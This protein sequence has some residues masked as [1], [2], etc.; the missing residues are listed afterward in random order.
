M[1]VAALVLS[2]TEAPPESLQWTPKAAAQRDREGAIQA[3]SSFGSHWGAGQRSRAKS[4]V[5]VG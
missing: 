2:D 3:G 4:G 1:R 5:G